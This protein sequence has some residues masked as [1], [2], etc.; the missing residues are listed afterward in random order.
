MVPNYNYGDGAL[1]YENCTF[2]SEDGTLLYGA[3]IYV[4]M[5]LYSMIMVLFYVMV[6]F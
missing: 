4:K 6:L 5:V 1:V 2:L 3:V